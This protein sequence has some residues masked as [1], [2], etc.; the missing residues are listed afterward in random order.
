MDLSRWGYLAIL[1]FVAA[2]VFAAVASVFVNRLLRRAPTPVGEE[3]RSATTVL[4]KLRTG[5]PMTPDEVDF[6]AQLVADRRSPMAYSIPAGLF[7]IGCLYVFGSLQQLHGAAPSLRTFI[8]VLPMLGAT[9]LTI[10]LLRISHLN[11]RLRGVEARRQP[12]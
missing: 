10:Q 9:N 12:G 6:A 2:L 4:M 1:A 11:G 3:I 5:K 8:G 7:A